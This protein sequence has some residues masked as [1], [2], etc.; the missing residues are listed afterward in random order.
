MSTNEDS[1]LKIIEDEK[2]GWCEYFGV[3]E[4]HCYDC[5]INTVDSTF[6]IQ[7][8]EAEKYKSLF[9]RAKK[10]SGVIEDDN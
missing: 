10:I 9:R 3:E 6:E 4:G 2:L 5:P 1:W 7:D 8:C